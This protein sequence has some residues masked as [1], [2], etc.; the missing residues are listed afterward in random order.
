LIRED[1]MIDLT[2]RII[3]VVIIIFLLKWV[4]NYF[5]YKGRE[6]REREEETQEME[7]RRWEKYFK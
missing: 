7:R 6:H 5:C 2:F 3:E 4:F 1:I